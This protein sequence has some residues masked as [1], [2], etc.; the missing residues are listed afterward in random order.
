M[1]ISQLRTSEAGK[2]FIKSWEAL[3]LSAYNDTE[4]NCTIGYGHL[5]ETQRC[6]NISLPTEFERGITASDA[7][8]YF[9]LDLIRFENGVKR[10]VGV[11]LFQYEFDALVSLLFNCG[12]FFF[13]ANGAPNLLRL[14]NSEKY[15]EAAN[16]FL[17][18]TNGG[19][20]G[21]AKGECQRIICF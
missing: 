12:E 16:E 3:R 8:R 14:V 6:E 4:G 18:I 5:I 15:E 11:K 20:P 19:D 1:D 10:D 21:L 9:Y 7:D 13:A 2:V 17:D